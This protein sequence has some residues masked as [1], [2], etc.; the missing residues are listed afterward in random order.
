LPAGAR[1]SARLA[2]AAREHLDQPVKGGEI[3]VP[4]GG[5]ATSLNLYGPAGLSET[6]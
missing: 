5:K 6:A 3:I 1:A 2:K 4:R